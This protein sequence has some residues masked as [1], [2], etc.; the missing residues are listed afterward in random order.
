MLYSIDKKGRVVDSDGALVSFFHGTNRQFTVHDPGKHRSQLNTKYQGDWICYSPNIDVGWAY[1]DAMRNQRLDATAF[2]KDVCELF[3]KHHF[4]YESQAKSLLH[5]LVFGDY[6]EAWNKLSDSV[7]SQVPELHPLAFFELQVAAW[8]SKAGVSWD[9]LLDL[10]EYIEGSACSRV[11]NDNPMI[12]IF[13]SRQGLHPSV[14]MDLDKLGFTH[15]RPIERVIESILT[16]TNMLETDCRATAKAAHGICDLVIYTGP[17][18]VQGVPEILVRDP[19]QVLPM[20]HHINRMDWT[21]CEEEAGQFVGMPNH[22]VV[23]AR[24]YEKH[25]ESNR[26]ASNR[27]ELSLA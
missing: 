27:T 6:D 24:D 11:D 15:C 22:S 20:R 13:S 19:E 10:T 7:I 1:S 23:S 2:E 25:F 3:E 17:G 5:D 21:E 26:I 8:A 14:F 18:T 4:D 9:V 12:D 16:A